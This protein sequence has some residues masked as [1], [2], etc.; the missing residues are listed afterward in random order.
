MTTTITVG[1]T[2]VNPDAISTIPEMR[3]E[4]Y[5]IQKETFSLSLQAHEMAGIVQSLAARLN[6]LV[7]A[8]EAGDQAALT[9]QLL[10]L[11]NMRN[12]E[13]AARRLH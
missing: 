2:L 7:D 6:A 11:Q 10:D 5:R 9:Q 8:H 12:K 13:L 3:A 4:L 1:L